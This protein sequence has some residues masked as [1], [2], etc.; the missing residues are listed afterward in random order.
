M[1]ICHIITLLW[2]VMLFVPS[3]NMHENMS[4]TYFEQLQSMPD[5][6][7][8]NGSMTG[9]RGLVEYDSV[10]FSDNSYAVHCL[11][12]A[13]LNS[14][15]EF[16]DNKGQ[17]IAT[18]ARASECYA[19]TMVYDYDD[20]GRLIHLLRYKSEI[21]DGLEPDSAGFGRTKEG[22]LGFRQM[23]AD[24]DYEHPDTAKYEQTNIEYDKTG[25]AVKAYVVYG[26]NSIAAPNGY[27]LVLSVK[28]CL[29]FWQS[30]LNGGFFI[31]HIMMVPK[32]KDLLDY[33]VCRFVDFLPSMESDYQ[34]GYI[35][36]TVWHHDPSMAPD[37]KDLVFTPVRVGDLNI[38]SVMRKDGSKY[39]RAYKNGLLAYKQEV[40]K[41]G[42]VLK[43]ASYSI[44]L[45][46]KVKVTYECIDYSTDTL[47]KESDF[48]MEIPDVE[49]FH[50]D[51]NVISGDYR[52]NNYYS[53]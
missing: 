38:Y 40:S 5:S 32:S 35:V 46:K 48:E 17:T 24:I 25:D 12:H 23:I 29:G 14:L 21:F 30:D 7:G 50:E 52:W 33:K 49:M 41:Y 47:K 1:R 39:Q 16:F 3:C 34:N 9:H 8:K 4:I 15:T 43:K 6:S 19:Q 13:P 28:P 36:K 42:T 20:K 51:M 31:F 37:D 27:K 11:Q 18:I 22:Y 2:V 26:K 45:G 44:M 53:K 10:R